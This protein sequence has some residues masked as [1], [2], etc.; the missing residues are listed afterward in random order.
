[1]Y[2]PLSGWLGKAL[3][4]A[5]SFLLVLGALE[6]ALRVLP[7]AQGKEREERAS[8]MQPDPYLGW[9][10][11]PGARVTYARREYTVEVA[12]NSKGLRDRERPYAR[13]PGTF[14]ILAL[15]DSFVEAYSVR[16]EACIT[17]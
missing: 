2:R 17:A 12:I 5:A 11:R 3:L 7:G 6:V 9:S 14:R 4:L 1:M 10:K 8:Y 13:V 16:F 15:G